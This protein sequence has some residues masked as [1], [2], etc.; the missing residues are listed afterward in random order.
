MYNKDRKYQGII[1]WINKKVGAF[2]G[3][4]KLIIYTSATGYTKRYA[5]WL[6]DRIGADVL[7]LEDASKESNR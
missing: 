6:A 2:T 5:E 1:G 4:K 3:M 7:V